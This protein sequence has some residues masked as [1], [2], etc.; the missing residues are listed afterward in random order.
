MGIP[1]PTVIEIALTTSQCLNK[2]SH[3]FPST[4]AQAVWPLAVHRGERLPHCDVTSMLDGILILCHQVMIDRLPHSGD[5]N[6][7]QLFLFILVHICKSTQK[8]RE[9][10]ISGNPTAIKAET[11]SLLSGS[12]S[13]R[14]IDDMLRNCIIYYL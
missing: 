8:R 1:H 9:I 2:R 11:G 14:V 7:S 10:K 4:L 12:P 6:R 3:G 13:L 5:A